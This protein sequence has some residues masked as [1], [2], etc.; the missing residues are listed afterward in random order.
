MLRLKRILVLEI[1]FWLFYFLYQWLG[2]SALSG[3]YEA[4]FVNACMALPLTFTV[5][6]VTVHV[7]VKK[8]YHKDEKIKFWLFQVSFTIMLLLLRRLINYYIIYPSYFP[9]AQL[10]PFFS[11]G[12]LII[13]LVNVYLVVGVYCLLYFVRSWHEE[14]QRVQNLLQ[15]KTLAELE[16][17]KAQVQ[18]HFIFNALNNIYSKALQSS[19]DTAKLLEHLSGFLSYNL[20]EARQNQVPL[21]SELEYIRHYLALQK[22]RYGNKVDLSVNIFDEIDELY[23]APM[24]LLPLVE[25]AFKHGLTDSLEQGWLRIDVLKQQDDFLV[26]IEN[27]VEEKAPLNKSAKEGIG[28]K[29]VERRLAL[30]YPGLHEFKIIKESHSYLTIIKIKTAK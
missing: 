19:P 21:K 12:K 4:Y 24:L 23:I 17:L 18:P 10:I 25:N 29:N 20:Y 7:F 16:L 8:L 5:A 3:Q 27:S 15:Q 30:T 2:L 22:N 13:E 6:Y 26:K 1:I 9:Q 28:V 11:L 14:R